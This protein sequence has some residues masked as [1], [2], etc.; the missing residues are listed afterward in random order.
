MVLEGVLDPAALVKVQEATERVKAMARAR[1]WHF[2]TTFDPEDWR[3]LLMSLGADEGNILALVVLAQQG[4]AG[5]VEANRLLWTWMKPTAPGTRPYVDAP[6]LFQASIRNA[7]QNIDQP[8]MTMYDWKAW[9]PGRAYGPY[10]ELREKFMGPQAPPPPNAGPGATWSGNP[11]SA[12][13]AAPGSPVPATGA[14]P[15]G[16]TPW[17]KLWAPWHSIHDGDL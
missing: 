15:V 17:K 7:R 5:R 2:R 8:P 16:W 1:F 13:G 4:I 9:V 14:A 11:I 3:N 6:G 10:W 12:A